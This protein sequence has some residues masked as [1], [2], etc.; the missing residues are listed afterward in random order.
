MVM[1]Y[2]VQ[3][4]L[5]GGD[6]LGTP[7]DAQIKAKLQVIDARWRASERAIRR[8]RGEIGDSDEEEGDTGDS[9]DESEDGSAGDTTDDDGEERSEE[10]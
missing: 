9:D 8:Y 3:N 6:V 5:L 7:T 4:T 2:L 10:Q 1:P